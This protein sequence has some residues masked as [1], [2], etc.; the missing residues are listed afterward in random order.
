MSVKILIPTPLRQYTEKKEVVEIEGKTAGEVLN[1]LSSKY[2]NLKKHLYNDDGSIRSYINIY[3]NEEDIRY[4]QKEKTS[5][6]DSDIISIIP[7]IAGGVNV[8]EHELETKTKID[9]IDLTNEE[10]LRYSRHLIIPEVGMIGQKKLKA[11]RVLM[12]GAGGL[13]SPV[14][15]YLAAAGVGHLGII[16]F[17]I[18]DQTNLQRQILHTTKDVGRSKLDSARETISEINPNVKIETYETRLTSENAL[19]IFSKYDLIVD[20]AD[21]FPTRYLVN[22]ACVLLGKPYVYGSIFRFDGQVT[23]FQPKDGPCYRCLYPAPPPPGLVPSCAEGG[24]LGILPGIIGSLQAL[25]AIKLIIGQGVP[26]IGRLL[27]FDALKLKFRELKLHK[28]PGC[29][30][31]GEHPTIHELIDYEAFCGITPDAQGLNGRQDQITVEELKS[32][33]DKGEDIFILDVREPH[34]YEICNLGGYLIPLNDLPERINELDTS[35]EIV[36]H[37]KVGG[38][39]AHAAAFLKKAGFKKVKNLIGGID[40]WAAKIDRTMPRY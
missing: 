40:A 25:E 26:L 28:N 32:K 38:R 19:E 34:E 21:N 30:V 23:V 22:D 20:G 5:I 13:G 37:C 1:N 39:S 9:E 10:I 8:Q 12:I 15:L 31:C 4:L 2:S 7:S 29:P 11:A 16:D 14:G 6:K 3:V 17:D 36:A 18:V 35:R 24:V 27:L 33:L